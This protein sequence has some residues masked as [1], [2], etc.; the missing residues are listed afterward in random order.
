MHEYEEVII[1]VRF[2]Y[3]PAILPSDLRIQ[4]KKV[5]FTRRGFLQ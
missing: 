1:G 3:T 4:R 5:F 2:F